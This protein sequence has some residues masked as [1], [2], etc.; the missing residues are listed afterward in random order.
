MI[1]KC[2]CG[3]VPKELFGRRDFI[4][5]GSLGFFGLGLGNVL[6]LQARPGESAA[7]SAVQGSAAD[8]SV[9]LIWLSG[10][11]PQM[12]TFDMKP[13]GPSNT[14]GLFK[15]I[16][17]NVA[18]IQVCEHLPHTAGQADKFAII[19]SM[20]SREA[21]HERAINYLLTGYL[22]L[23]TLEFPSM[24]SVVAKEKGSGN[25]LPPYVTIPNIFP[26]FGAGF[27][28]GE[29]GPFIAG[30]PNVSGYRVRDLNL[31]TDID[32]SRINN[33]KW[34]LNEIDSQF[35]NIDATNEFETVDTFYE[36]AY[37]L[38]RSTVAKKAF[39]IG[40]EPEAIRNR[41]GRTPVGQGCLL[42]R[43]LVESGVRFVTV[44]KGWLN[45]DTHGRNFTTLEKLLLP[46]LDL[47]YSALLED[48]YQRSL[49]ESTLVVM[50]GEFGRT[51]EVNADAGRDHWSKAFSIVLAGG[52]VRGGQVLGATDAKAAEVTEDP[53]QVE[54]L[55]ATIYDRVGIDFTKEYHT[56]IG[57]PVK[58]SNGG[59]VISKLFS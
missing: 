31:P 24:G 51:P 47:A 38:V 41:Y 45:W 44:S 32:W 8:R 5:V 4:K 53:Y 48:L 23:Q 55:V 6:A 7:H 58:L 17:T 21:N 59:Q 30:D 22:P 27:L 18:G 11:P 54:D 36:R 26:S 49:L 57:R 16:A 9:I 3:Q 39:D 19:R 20:T 43:R 33:R 56:P 10:G 42:A 13:E 35:R 28:G 15:P 12:D 40:A 34:L 46:E 37:D 2:D 1:F 29:Y 52:G 25:G 50:M 14:R